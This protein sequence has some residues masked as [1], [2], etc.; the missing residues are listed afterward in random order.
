MRQEFDLFRSLRG[1]YLS[2]RTIRGIYA[3]VVSSLERFTKDAPLASVTYE[4]L[5]RWIAEEMKP[6]EKEK[7]GK[8]IAT[9][10]SPI[11]MNTYIR[12]IKAFAAFFQ[13]EGLIPRE[14]PFVRLKQIP[15]RPKP[16]RFLSE[17]EFVAIR[18]SEPNATLRAMYWTSFLSGLRLSD[19]VGL[20]WEYVDLEREMFRVPMQKTGRVLKAPMHW[21]LRLIFRRLE[22][23]RTFVFSEP[24]M[25]ED[26]VSHRFK[27]A[28]RR[29]GIE[30]ANF[31]CLRKSFASHLAI[32]GVG[33]H[34][35][36]YL[37][38]HSSVDLTSRTYSSL[39]PEAVVDDVRRIGDKAIE[40]VDREEDVFSRAE[41]F[42]PRPR[43]RS[44]LLPMTTGDLLLNH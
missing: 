2:E 7:N 11:G 31:H 44:A 40:L 15:T 38:G 36:S 17:E 27:K 39:T 12:T 23:R 8:K 10:R 41:F 42:G 35:I 1:S 37:L 26:F 5:L 3:S 24:K 21:I 13:D 30:D 33:I 18:N 34:R 4:D 19:V 14:N 20:K 25:R 28:A 6:K 16:V 9:K 29:A 22:S 32:A 43:E